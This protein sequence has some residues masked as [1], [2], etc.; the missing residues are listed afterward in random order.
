[1]LR[2]RAGRQPVPPRAEGVATQ[3]RRQPRAGTERRAEAPS[4]KDD[5]LR[6][7]S[8]QVLVAQADPAHPVLP[9]RVAT[10]HADVRCD[11]NAPDA[12]HDLPATAQDHPVRPART[13][14]PATHRQQR[15]VRKPVRLGALLLPLLQL[16]DLLVLRVHCIG[17]QRRVRAG[18]H[19][20]VTHLQHR[21]MRV[22]G[23]EP[24]HATVGSGRDEERSVPCDGEAGA[25]EIH[26]V[27]VWIITASASVT[28]GS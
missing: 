17:N 19:T 22:A 4:W 20:D 10:V 3:A 1:M 5:R 24:E 18:S 28:F 7:V 8:G 23:D 9:R 26:A 11:R 27:G 12:T 21:A 16:L 14:A 13:N 6:A 15:S 25:V 2:A